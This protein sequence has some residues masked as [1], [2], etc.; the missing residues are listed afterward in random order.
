MRTMYD[1]VTAANIPADAQMVAGYI[2]MITLRPWSPADWARFPGA[3][4]V[5]IVTKASTN[6]G[7]VLDVEP[8]DATPGEAPGWVRMRRAAGATPSIYCNLSTWPAVRAAFSSAGVAEPYYWIAHYDGDPAIP[9]GAVAKQYR[10]DVAPGFDVSS[11][12]DHWPGVDLDEPAWTGVEIM[13]R[14]TVTPPNDDVNSVRLFLSGSP[15]AA[16]VVRPPLNGDGYADPIWVSNI[17]AWGSDHNGIG[18]NPAQADGYD[19]QL[20]SH[21]RYDLPGA[22]WADV[23]YS[24]GQPFD[25]DIVG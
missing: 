22:L 24:A 5:T 12:A 14:I 1:A 13:E 10:G 9:D 8:G 15:G 2:D 18:H 6:D 4:K 20:V 19:P 23:N 7:H 3:V 21:R 11:V 17:F 16:I 25:I